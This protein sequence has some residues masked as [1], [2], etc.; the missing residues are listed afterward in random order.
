M[1]CL[2]L[3]IDVYDKSAAGGQNDRTW[4]THEYDKDTFW[5]HRGTKVTNLLTQ[6]NS[7][8]FPVWD[9]IA[10]EL[11]VAGEVSYQNWCLILRTA[12]LAQIKFKAIDIALT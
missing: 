3:F 4:F 1:F 9:G 10:V 11:S 8:V 6:Y 5:S 12:A 7:H 2:Q